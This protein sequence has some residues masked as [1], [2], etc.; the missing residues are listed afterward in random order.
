MEFGLF[1]GGHNF[2]NE[3]TERQL[4]VDLLEQAVLADR[5]GYDTVW[6]PEHHLNNYYLLPDPFQMAVQILER[7]RRI[8]V[9]FGV[10]ILPNHHP[11]AL[12]GKIAQLDVLYPGRIE[13]GVGRGSSGYEA[14]RFQN[15]M[16]AESGRRHFMETLDI[17]CTGL[18]SPGDFDY[19]GEFF[20]FERVTVL[21]RPLTTPMPPV[22]LA[23][24][25]PG[26]VYGQ[27]L[28][29]AKLGIPTR[30]FQSPF[31]NPLSYVEESFA[32]FLK[33]LS[34]TGVRR[35]DAYYAVNR[36][37]FVSNDRRD[38][39]EA[40]PR[41]QDLNRGLYAQ[42]EKSEVYVDGQAI[43]HPVQN[44][45]SREELLLN[46]PV[47]DVAHVLEHV[48]ALKDLGVDHLSSYFD[49][50]LP[51]ASTLRSMTLFADDVMEKFQTTRV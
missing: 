23:A 29:A 46:N 14:V 2:Y 3:R 4:F 19:D 37:T 6:L 39:D 44:E 31:R 38:L 48:T 27:S 7:T 17:L 21:P 49:L 10:L 9:G 11:L 12:A 22:W 1:L 45:V 18:S 32:G 16:D 8:R 30:I 33:G 36:T 41:L 40:I 47:G 43:I 26:A 5:L 50:A 15:A 20:Q 51:Q 35:E 25:A 24:L 28:N 42:I 34:E 13:V